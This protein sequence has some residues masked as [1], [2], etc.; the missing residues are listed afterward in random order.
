V[1]ETLR[2]LRFSV[3]NSVRLD[4]GDYKARQALAQYIARPPLWLQKLSYDRAGSKVLYHTD[5]NPYLKQNTTLWDATDFIAALTQLV[6]PWGVRSIHYYG[7]YS[8]R[9]KAGWQLLPHVAHLAPEAWKDSHTREVPSEPTPKQSLTVRQRAC[10]SAW[11]RL[12]AKV[13]E[14]DPLMCPR[15]GSEMKL[16]AVITDPSEVHTILRHLIKIGRAP[17]GLDPS[18][19][20]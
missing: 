9:C 2:V 11:A 8:S 19:L 10:R 14:L 16:I 15:C 20:N 13:Y 5:H 6:P 4:G 12:I 18:S 3:D 1:L 17:P 7:L